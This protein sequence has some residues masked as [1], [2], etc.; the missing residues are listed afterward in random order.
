LAALDAHCEH[1]ALGGRRRSQTE[2]AHAAAVAEAKTSLLAQAETSLLAQAE[3]SLL[4]QAETSLLAQ[5][6]TSLLAQAET[7]L[8]AQAETSLLAQAE[9]S[10]LAQ[11]ETSSVGQG[12]HQIKQAASEAT[13]VWAAACAGEV[14][15]SLWACDAD[16]DVFSWD[17]L[18]RLSRVNRSG[19][20]SLGEGE[21][22][23]ELTL[24][25]DGVER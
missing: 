3:T 24:V 9:T 21:H 12:V 23:V 13:E 17:L 16:L 6:G 10:L 5:A 22:G 25:Y 15:A 14:A 2:T 7:S 18:S 11:A 19:V 20:K 8:L 4:A 1:L